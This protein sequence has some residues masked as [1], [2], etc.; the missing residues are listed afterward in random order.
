MFFSILNVVFSV[1]K[2]KNHELC[3]DRIEK[4]VILMMQICDPADG[5]FYPTLILMMNSK[6]RNTL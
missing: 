4:L 1:S 2:K 5:F 3:E 6:L